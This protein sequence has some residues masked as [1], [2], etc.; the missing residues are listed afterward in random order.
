MRKGLIVTGGKLDQ[1]FA[2][3]FL[4]E[5][6][7]DKIIAVDA[8][9][10]V[11]DA[12]GL[13]PDYVVGDFDTADE[14]LMEKYKKMPHIVWEVHKPEKDETDTELARSCAVALRCE[15][16]AFLGATGG[17]LDHLIGN[18]HALYDCMQRGIMA[19]LI[20]GQNKLY[21]M[22]EGKTFYR[23]R[24]WGKYVS[25]LPYTETVHGITLRGFKY[26]LTKKDIRRGEEVGLCISNE[27]VEE[28]AEIGFEDGV[29]ICVE[30]HD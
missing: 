9:L 16:I 20:D 17:R 12:L 7:F 5:N 28:R 29:L 24:Q 8:G 4:D 21:L 19:Y 27:V 15:E 18:I 13:V 1:A 3:S 14:A 11:T 10:A 6:H 26:P 2:R 23:N 30:S 22:D 25:F